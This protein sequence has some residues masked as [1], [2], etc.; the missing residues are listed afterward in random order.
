M[1]DI[2]KN[3]KNNT[4]IFFEKTNKVRRSFK[5]RYT[6]IRMKDG[7]LLTEDDKIAKTFKNRFHTLLNQPRSDVISEECDT[8]EQNIKRPSIE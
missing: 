6:M 7:T 8:V 2:E 4:K 1:K 3:R 5:T